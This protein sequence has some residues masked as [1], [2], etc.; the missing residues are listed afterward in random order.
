MVCCSADSGAP[1]QHAK[2]WVTFVH[3][4]I[5]RKSETLILGQ[6]AVPLHPPVTTEDC[7]SLGSNKEQLC[8]YGTES[9]A[10]YPSMV[11]LEGQN[12]VGIQLPHKAQALAT[13]NQLRMVPVQWTAKDG[14]ALVGA[15]YEFAG[16][17]ATAP[18][19]VHAHGGPAIMLPCDRSAAANTCRYPYR[20]LLLASETPSVPSRCSSPLLS[21]SADVHPLSW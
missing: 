20:H 8:C 11:L 19:L 5:N 15:V 21:A 16:L 12:A 17:A 4:G 10:D 9:G 14:T 3:N 7:I 6:N 13:F 1:R 18:L 2:L